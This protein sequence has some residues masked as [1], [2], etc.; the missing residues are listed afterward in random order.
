[1]EGQE[2]DKIYG[3]F[4]RVYDLFMDEVPYD[5]WFDYLLKLLYGQGIKDGMVADLA[6][7][8]GEFT[9]RLR[10]AGYHVIGVDISQEMLEIASMKCQPDVLLLR[11]D[12]RKL[13]LHGQ[14]QAAVCLCD[15]MN[16]M[17]SEQELQEVFSHVAAGLADGGVF[18]FDMKTSYYFQEILGDGIFADNREN[19]SYIWDNEYDAG[20]QVNTYLLTL[21]ELVDDERDLFVRTDELHRQR[22]YTAERVKNLLEQSGFAVAGIYEVLTGHAPSEES[23]RIYFVARNGEKYE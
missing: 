9:R 19:A 16:Y 12:M 2:K 22:A 13:Q 15:G 14:A 3:G 8:T 17:M 7:G 4:A 1:M 11:Q 18:I 21:Y 23:E 20:E 5:D 6:C 10:Q